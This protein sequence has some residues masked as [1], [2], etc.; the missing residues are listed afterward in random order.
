M[1]NYYAKLQKKYHAAL[2]I[3]LDKEV[4]QDWP[5]VMRYNLFMNMHTDFT[6][7]MLPTMYGLMPFCKG[8]FERSKVIRY[9]DPKD[10]DTAKVLENIQE[11]SES[12]I[13]LHPYFAIQT[14]EEMLYV[15]FSEMMK[16]G[17]FVK[18]CALCDKYF[19]LPDK[20]KR[21]Y[22]DRVYMN[23]RTCKQ[24]GAK[25]KFN[26][27]IEDDKFLQ[28]FQTIY[29]RM[30]SRYYRMDALDSDRETNKLTEEEF[31]TW[32]ENASKIRQEYRLGKIT[33]E[34]MIETIKQI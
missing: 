26:K 12:A 22:C 19:V 21:D 11:N 18:R 6:Q 8:K 17:M 13:N 28:E 25:L 32:S 23:G 27:T 5:L 30:Y 14:L 2:D 24:V 29:N 4:L 7:Y 9:S 1:F 16:R 31:K 3:C 34:E 15:E 33:W 20:R 10:V